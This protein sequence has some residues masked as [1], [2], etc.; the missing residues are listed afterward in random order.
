MQFYSTFNCLQLWLPLN[1]LFWVTLPYN[2]FLRTWFKA[3][4]IAKNLFSI[5]I[6]FKFQQLCPKKGN[7]KGL[8]F[9]NAFNYLQ[10]CYPRISNVCLMKLWDLSSWVVEFLLYRFLENVLS[11]T[12]SKMWTIQNIRICERGI[13]MTET[14]ISPRCPFLL[15]ELML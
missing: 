4:W 12:F 8:H 2:F 14:I 9:Y 13:F 1:V 5:T 11:E 15:S 6:S 3:A 10:L 7:F